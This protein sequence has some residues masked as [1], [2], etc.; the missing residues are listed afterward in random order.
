MINQNNQL[1]SLAFSIAHES[2]NSL[3]GISQICDLMKENISQLNEFFDLVK[4]TAN[5]SLQVN[6]MILQ[7]VKEGE[8]DKSNFV[9]LSIATIVQLA[10][11]EF[12]FED[13]EQKEFVDVDLENDFMFLGDQTLMIFVL[14]NLLKNSL[15]YNAKIE[16]WLNSKNK[17][18]YFKDDG[19][20]ISADKLP[21]IFTH[22]FLFLSLMSCKLLRNRKISCVICDNFFTSNKKGGTGLGLPFCKRV[23]QAFGGDIFCKSIAGEGV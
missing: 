20:G 10:I 11:K 17:T 7:N 13:E 1:K 9:N 6:E 14:F 5:R 3:G 21:Y 16:I 18:L 4:T 12:V 15:F 8:I 22:I 23:M 19:V 2:R